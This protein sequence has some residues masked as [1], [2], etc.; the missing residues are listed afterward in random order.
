MKRHLLVR[1]IDW[2][3]RYFFIAQSALFTAGAAIAW[4]ESDQRV[5]WL[6]VVGSL[7]CQ[8]WHALLEALRRLDRKG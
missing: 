5:F 1:V 8:A 6:C 3:D 2:F 4:V 7:F